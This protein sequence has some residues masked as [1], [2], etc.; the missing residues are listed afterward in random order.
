M[1]IPL[2]VQFKTRQG[3]VTKDARI[4]NGY[5]EIKGEVGRVRKRPG[6]TDLGLIGVGD[7][8]FLGCVSLTPSGGNLSSMIGSTLIVGD[9]SW[10][11]DAPEWDSGTTYYYGD[12]VF[13]NGQYW[14]YTGSTGTSGTPPSGGS[15]WG[16]SANPNDTYDNTVTYNIGDSVIYQ[17]VQKYA[18]A[19]VTGVIPSNA[20]VWNNTP[21]SAIR[22]RGSFSNIPGYTPEGA[23]I[24]AAAAVGFQM[25]YATEQH[26][27]PGVAPYYIWYTSEY[28][29]VG[30]VVNGN[31][32]GTAGVRLCGDPLNGPNSV[33][34][35][36]ITTV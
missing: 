33:A 27:C 17:G 18:W 13:Y 36:T 19:S 14:Y 32:Y 28:T 10:N 5:V 15:G 8:Y 1:R 4:K 6:N 23:S 21:P 3:N 2:P 24:A 20:D 35:G 25:F 16:N 31:Q 9:D 26:S 12:W 29:L 7:A 34:V 22:Y 30:S 11:V